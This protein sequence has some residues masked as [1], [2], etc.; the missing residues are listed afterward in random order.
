MTIRFAYFLGIIVLVLVSC[1][2]R[3]RPEGGPKDFDKPIMVRSDPDFK[4]LHF[5]EDEIRLYFDEFVKLKDVNSQLIVSPP[6]KYP[7]LIS[8]QGTPSKR[9][10]IQF[11]DTLQENTT[12]SFNFGQSIQDNTEGNI[13]ENFKFIVSTGDYIDSLFVGGRIKDAY[14][15]NM[16]DAP[17]I[18]LYPVDENYK[19]SIVFNEKPTYVGSTLDSIQWSVTNIKPGKYRLIALNDKNKNYTYDPKVDRIAFHDDLIELPGDT[20]Y[21]MRLFKAEFP[22]RV[23]S[24][25]KEESKGH[26]LIGFEGQPKNLR[27]LEGSSTANEFVSSYYKDREKDTI[28][29]WMRG[30][31]GDSISLV[32]Q[33]ESYL[34][35]LNVRLTKEELDSMKVGFSHRGVLNPADTFKILTS[36]PIS[37]LDTSKVVFLNKDSLGVEYQPELSR[38]KDRI[39]LFFPFEFQQEYNLQLL[40]GAITD[41]MGVTND[42]LRINVRTGK[43]ADYCSVFLSLNNIPRYPVIVELM[44]DRGVVAGK[45]IAEGPGELQFI[46]IEPSRFKVR[47]IYDDNRNGKWDTGDFLRSV[48]PEEVYYFKSVIEAKAN[49]EVIESLSL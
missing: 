40:P 30:F 37:K 28:H 6:L 2:R 34:D 39:N 12:Y 47:I 27:I 1:A 42:S 21:D 26:I 46:N 4:S 31:E 35:T 5:D 23:V 9:I 14:E 11:R 20:V 49:W 22:F 17:T 19:D 8:P 25:A 7:L 13:L 15:L 36:V 44:D 43:T 18:M 24:R 16:V 10:S 41:I 3:G 48:Q 33:S 29:Y 32:V 45:K 38:Q